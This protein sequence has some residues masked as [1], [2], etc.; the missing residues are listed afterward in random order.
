[1][2]VK[3][4]KLFR[5][6]DKNVPRNPGDVFDVTEKRFKELNSTKFGTLVEEIQIKKPIKSR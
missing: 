6:K 5:D 1:M 4:L 3:A 2:K